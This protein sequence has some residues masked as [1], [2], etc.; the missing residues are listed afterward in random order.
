[1]PLAERR[2]AVWRLVSIRV[3]SGNKRQGF[4]LLARQANEPM[5]LSFVLVM[6]VLPVAIIATAVVLALATRQRWS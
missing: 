2:E 6:F 5:T 1:L 4:G 3:T